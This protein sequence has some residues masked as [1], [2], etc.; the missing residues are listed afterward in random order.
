MTHVPHASWPYH[1]E[2]C[3]LCRAEA[4]VRHG[5]RTVE[6]LQAA[7]AGLL[8]TAALVALFLVGSAR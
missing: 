6:F 2:G 3:E 4:T 5:R 8:W 1:G 7:L